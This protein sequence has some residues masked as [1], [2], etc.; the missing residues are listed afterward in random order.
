MSTYKRKA[1]TTLSRKSSAKRKLTYKKKPYVSRP[2][3]SF[4][5]IGF[6]KT[7]KFIHKYC[8]SVSVSGSAGLP[9]KYQFSCNGL[10]DPNITGSG[11]QPYYFD[12]VAGLYNQYR[13]IGA[14]IRGSWS[15]GS[16][17]TVP[18]V[19]GVYIDDD[20]TAFVSQNDILEQKSTKWTSI[21]PAT[22]YMGNISTTWSSKDQFGP[23]AVDQNFQGTGSAN[24]TEQQYFTFFGFAQDS[25]SA[26]AGWLTVEIEYIA[27][28]NELRTITGS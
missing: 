2:V 7:L 27:L 12:Q 19:F 23:S 25:T 24:P 26:V 18:Y 9:F 15:T 8:E 16:G 20:T 14:K 11:H 5:Q 17:T 6:P 22:P 4:N 1:T 13:V 3:R 21:A 10:Q 28:W